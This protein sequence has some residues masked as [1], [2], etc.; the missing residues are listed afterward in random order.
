M[1]SN[2]D[3]PEDEM[4]LAEL[5]AANRTEL[6]ARRGA[7][8]RWPSAWL[9]LAREVG[10]EAD[11]HREHHNEWQRSHNDRRREYE[12][13]RR[14]KRNAEVLRWI[15]NNAVLALIWAR[16]HSLWKKQKNEEAV[17]RYR[18]ARRKWQ[19][20]NRERLNEYR[21]HKWAT[22][23]SWRLRVEAQ[24]NSWRAKNRRGSSVCQSGMDEYDWLLLSGEQP[25]ARRPSQTNRE[26][27]NAYARAWRQRNPEKVRLIQMRSRQNNKTKYR[28]RVRERQRRYYEKNRER[29]LEY[30]R[31]WKAANRDRINEWQRERRKRYSKTGEQS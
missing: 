13:R 24:N 28:D 20:E 5:I 10:K 21:R 14:D 17:E 2:D 19:K 7:G 25:T 27:R 9:L 15:S 16:L 8:G 31:Q 12:K 22:D 11:Y 1:K 4:L 3:I 29:R 18:V 6:A 23:P 26:K 30:T